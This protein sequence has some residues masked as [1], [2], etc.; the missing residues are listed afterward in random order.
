MGLDADKWSGFAF[1]MGPDRMTMRKYG[2]KDIRQMWG[3]DL[4]FLK[5]F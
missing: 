2:I 4:R 3:N 1:G 5:Q